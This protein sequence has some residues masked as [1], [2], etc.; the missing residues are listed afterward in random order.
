[1]SRDAFAFR[2]RSKSSDSMNAWPMP[3]PPPWWKLTQVAPLAVLSRAFSSGQS[4]TASLP[5]RMASVSRSGTRR[6]RNRDARDRQS[7]VR[8]YPDGHE[9]RH[10]RPAV[11]RRT[12]ESIHRI[13]I[14]H[15]HRH[16]LLVADDQFQRDAIRKFDGYRMQAIQ[17]PAQC[18]QAQRR[19]MRIRLQQQQRRAILLAQP[20]MALQEARR[21]AVVLLGEDQIE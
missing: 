2:Q 10:S 20:G 4:L 18:M 9:P 5:S 15:V 8:Q 7:C 3:T 14:I 6:C 16:D 17:F 1:F 13:V 19:M 21:A 12:H 11:R